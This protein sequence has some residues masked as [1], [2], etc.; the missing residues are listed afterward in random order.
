ML[1]EGA[2][3]REEG[4][5]RAASSPFLM[6]SAGETMP[7][8]GLMILKCTSQALGHEINPHSYQG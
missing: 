6:P 4:E 1:S 8:E 2:Q 7:A 3:A 5:T